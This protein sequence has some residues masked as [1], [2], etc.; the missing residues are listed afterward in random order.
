MVD[1]HFF[2]DI[3]VFQSGYSESGHPIIFGQTYHVALLVAHQR[4]A[5]VFV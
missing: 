5:K 3:V 4:A 2:L 1:Q